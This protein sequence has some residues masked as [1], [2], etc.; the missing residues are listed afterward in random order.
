[1]LHIQRHLVSSPWL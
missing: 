1:M